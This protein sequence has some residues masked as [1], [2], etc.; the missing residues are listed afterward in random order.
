MS[1]LDTDGD[2]AIGQAEWD[3]VAC[4][5]PQFDAVDL[6]HDGAISTAELLQ[7]TWRQNPLTF[8][9]PPVRVAPGNQLQSDY[10]P[11]PWSV[12]TLRDALN[13]AAAEVKAADPQVEVPEAGVIAQAAWGGSLR[14]PDVRS[15]IESLREGYTRAR[16][17]APSLFQATTP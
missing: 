13:F 8:D 10:F 12:R 6:D 11:T 5:A 3:A 2:G 17:E 7:V 15:V 16:L 1:A 9:N 14:S 4:S